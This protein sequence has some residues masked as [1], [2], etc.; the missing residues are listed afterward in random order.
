MEK[1]ENRQYGDIGNIFNLKFI[2]YTKSEIEWCNVQSENKDLAAS[3]EKTS[4]NCTT[5][6]H[7]TEITVEAIQVVLSFKISNNNNS[8]IYTVT[9]CNGY[10]NNKFEVEIELVTTGKIVSYMYFL[11][12]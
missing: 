11:H 1:I 9:I 6:F 4:V 7:G 5:I 3:M 12:K 10:G 2:V 8:Q